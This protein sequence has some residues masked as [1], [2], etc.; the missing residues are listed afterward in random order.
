MVKLIYL[1]VALLGLS[2]Q[3]WTITASAFVMPAVSNASGAGAVAPN[4]IMMGFAKG[5]PGAVAP[6]APAVATPTDTETDATEIDDPANDAMNAAPTP[7]GPA[8]K[9]KGPK[10][11]TTMVVAAMTTAAPTPAPQPQAMPTTT[12]EAA[13]APKPQ[14]PPPPPKKTDTKKMTT[15]TAIVV[16]DPMTST[17]TA[18]SLLTTDVSDQINNQ[19]PVDPANTQQPSVESTAVQSSLTIATNAMPSSSNKNTNNGPMS[20]PGNGNNNPST[21]NPNNM[22]NNTTT[23]S[24]SM[25][26]SSTVLAVACVGVGSIL[27]VALSV[28]IYRHRKNKATQAKQQDLEDAR[29]RAE[30]ASMGS[31]LLSKSSILNRPM[32]TATTVFDNDVYMEVPPALTTAVALNE[33]NNDGVTRLDSFA[34]LRKAAKSLM[35]IGRSDSVVVGSN[36]VKIWK[37]V[38]KRG[39]VV[40]TADGNSVS[41]ISEESGSGSGSGSSEISYEMGK[42]VEYVNVPIVE[43]VVSSCGEVGSVDLESIVDVEG[44]NAGGK[45]G[46]MDWSQVVRIDSVSSKVEDGSTADDGSSSI[47]I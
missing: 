44:L 34:K 19:Y 26:P 47:N 9:G 1:V 22:D 38:L 18:T 17:S 40:T 24:S 14:P 12:T 27:L 29:S 3:P 23:S 37:P 32:S 21:N 25:G 15:S 45:S 7:A 20:V 43:R 11:T 39:G 16:A 28:G 2:Q 33:S 4:V 13:P 30:R 35:E 8:A 41:T 10:K 6:V 42:V 36:G 5:G 31:V 46:V